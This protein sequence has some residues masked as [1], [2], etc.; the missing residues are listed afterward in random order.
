[1]NLSDKR[2]IV[3]ACLTQ[4]GKPTFALAEVEVTE[5]GAEN[6]VHY[7]LVEAELLQHGYEEP[8]VHFDGTESPAFLHA[9]V[10]DM[11]DHAIITVPTIHVPP[12][13]TECLASSK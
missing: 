4:S 10:R 3:T 5:E 2:A 8:F 6:G 13:K 1:M 7:Y 11:L 12:E 9:A